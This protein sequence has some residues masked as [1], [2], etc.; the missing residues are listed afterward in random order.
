MKKS[1]TAVL[2]LALIVLTFTACGPKTGN[3][4][5]AASGESA[6]EAVD[7]FLTA[8]KNRDAETVSKYLEKGDA[9]DLSLDDVSEMAGLYE[10]VLDFDYEIVSAKEKNDSAQVKVKI[11]TYHFGEYFGQVIKEYLEEMLSSAFG[12]IQE[13]GSLDEMETKG[14]LEEVLN[15]NLNLLGEKNNEIETEIDLKKKNG[16]WKITTAESLSNGLFGGALDKMKE[17][18]GN[19]SW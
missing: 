13:G 8:V 6:K 5:E 18:F 1:I 12:M 15:R 10:K 7:A 16:E 19:I 14:K 3:P 4:K 11:K 17:A 9:V 2:I